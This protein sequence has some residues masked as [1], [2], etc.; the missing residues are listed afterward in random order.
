MGHIETAVGVFNA[1]EVLRKYFRQYDIATGEERE[2]R[3]SALIPMVVV[4]IFGIEVGI[5]AIIEKQGK[6][7]PRE[8]DLLALYGELE[9]TIK[10]GIEERLEGYGNNLPTAK[11]LLTYHRKSFEEWRYTQDF[12]HAL[13]VNPDAVAITL[14]SIIDVHNEAY[15][16][17]SRQVTDSGKRGLAPPSVQRAATEYIEGVIKRG[18]NEATNYE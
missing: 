12:G 3:T 4:Y 18:R 7:P 5:K 16:S 17:G 15:G 1:G 8:H 2:R 9:D 13:A 11:S 10:K 14:R 6:R